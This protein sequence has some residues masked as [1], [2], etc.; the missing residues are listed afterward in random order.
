M[1]ISTARTKATIEFNKKVSDFN[2]TKPIN[3]AI[4]HKT[5][6]VPQMIMFNV[7]LFFHPLFFFF[8]IR[9]KNFIKLTIFGS[10]NR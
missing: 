3:K 4:L 7:I 9:F 1:K 10:I 8:K 2:F 6:N 5:E